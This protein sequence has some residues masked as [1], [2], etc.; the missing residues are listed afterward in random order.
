MRE[1]RQKAGFGDC[2]TYYNVKQYAGYRPTKENL[3]VLDD[4]KSHRKKFFLIWFL[5]LLGSLII[6]SVVSVLSAIYFYK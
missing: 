4:L 6:L 3:K 5:S 2:E 1:I